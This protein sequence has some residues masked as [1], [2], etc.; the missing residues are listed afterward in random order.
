MRSSLIL[1]VALSFLVS[2]NQN[3]KENMEKWKQEVVETELNFSKMAKEKGI[4]NAFLA[5]A[6]DSVVL[7]RNQTLIEG[8]NEMEAYFVKNSNIFLDNTLDWTPDYVDVSSSGDLAYTY[9]KY[10]FTYKDSLGNKVENKGVF[11]TVWKR[12][13]NG[14]WKF[15]WD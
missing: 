1:V 8:K 9:G 10:T 7:L 3:G 2:C 11:H 12:Q 15:V 5:F 6:A 14:E 4:S 13:S